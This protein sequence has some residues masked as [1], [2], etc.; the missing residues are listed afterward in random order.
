MQGNILPGPLNFVRWLPIFEGPQY[1]T[2]FLSVFGAYNFD[3]VLDFW[4]ICLKINV[5]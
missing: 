4:K 3:V 1:G 2:S 5:V